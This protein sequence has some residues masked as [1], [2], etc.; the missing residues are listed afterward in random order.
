MFHNVTDGATH[1]SISRVFVG[2]DTINNVIILEIFQRF[3]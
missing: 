3:F 1:P 2:Y